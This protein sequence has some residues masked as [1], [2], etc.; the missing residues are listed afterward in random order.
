MAIDIASGI[1]HLERKEASIPGRIALIWDRC[2]STARGAAESV[3]PLGRGWTNRYAATL[4]RFEKGFRIVTPTGAVELLPDPD[5]AVES[6]GVVRHFGAFLEV[7]KLDGRYVV[8]SWNVDSGRIW[9]YC[10]LAG[11]LGVP[12]RLA[13][14][15][16][17]SGRALELD[18]DATS[19]LRR[20]RQVAEGRELLLHYGR[21]NLI[22]SV[23]LSASGESNVIA[24]YEYDAQGRLS[25]AYDAAGFGDHFEYDEK[26][27]VSRE[28][29]KDGGVFHYRYD[30]RGRCVLR[31]GLG[32]YDQKRLRFL[33]AT[34]TIEV[35]N[36]RGA[37]SRY[38]T[39]PTGQILNEWS[40][41]GAHHGRSFDA[42]GRLV[43]TVDSTGAMTRYGYDAD[44]NRSLVIDALGHRTRYRYNQ[45]HQPTL[46]VDAL[47]QEWQREYD[48]RNRLIRT[49][50]PLG[51]SWQF[52]Y[53]EADNL[54]EIVNPAGA[55]RL[56]SFSDGVLRAYKDWNGGV[57]GFAFDPFGRVTE[58]RDPLERSTR[59][60]YDRLGRPIQI[61]RPDQS[62]VLATY[63]PGGNLASYVDPN[64]HTRR[65]KHGPCGR[66]LEAHDPMGRITRYEWGTE[67][68]WLQAIVNPK[69]ERYEFFRDEAGHVV[70][71]KAFDG[72]ERT[73]KYNGEDRPVGMTTAN[74]ETIE[75]LRDACQRVT[76]QLLPDGERV[77]FEF[78]PL[79]RL[80]KAVN[81]DS[82]LV[83]ERDAAGR[84]TR[85]IQG[86][87]WVSTRY[88]LAGE[89]IE[90]SSSLGQRTVFEQDA[91][92]GL[93]QMST[94]NGFIRFEY[95]PCGREVSRLL[96]GG[97]RLDQTHD[98][99]GRLSSQR[100]TD[101]GGQRAAA[102]AE[103]IRRVYQHDAAGQIIGVDDAY[104]GRA[105]LAYD[106]AEGLIECIAPAV[107]S[108]TFGYDDTGNI[109]HTR[110]T[111]ALARDESW[112]IGVGDR[113]QQ[114]GS[115]EHRYDPEGRLVET[116]DRTTA[117]KPLTWRYEW[118][119]LDRLRTLRRPDGQTWRYAYDPLSRRIAKE[120]TEDGAS[121]CSIAFV[122]DRERLVHECSGGNV[123]ST[124]LYEP[125][126][127]SPIATI[128]GGK[129]YCIVN[130]A[131]GTPRELLDENGRVALRLQRTAWG[132]QLSP[133]PG[134][135]AQVR[136][137]IA[138]QGQWRDDESGLHYNKFRYY[139]PATGRFISQDPIRLI[140]GINL[141][142]YCRNPIN[143]IDPLGLS[144]QSDSAKRGRD[145]A[146]ADLLAAG[147][148]IK[149]EEVTMEV[150]GSRIRADFV[151]EDPA[152]NL[153][154]IEVK[155]GTGRLTEN[156]TNA[157]VFDMS[158]P[159]NASPHPGG[160]I[161]T[162]G[163]TTATFTTST[164]NV[165]KTTGAG[166]PPK[167]SS[168]TA[169][170]TVLHY[171]E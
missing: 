50:D 61:V 111:G 27:R 6:G 130:D 59:I 129:T 91:V 114:Q 21:S 43:S 165:N 66:L 54:T 44:G 168:G 62:Q 15:E 151:T 118:D 125:G 29:A 32:H 48:Q 119:V 7:F 64:G 74:G 81:S 145:A 143:W 79:G 57:H 167:G 120:C 72:G 26:H 42:F 135:P 41:L 87:H 102:G 161:D 154:V 110:R 98:A 144:C 158:N 109:A 141:Y 142:A 9:R 69:G 97:N 96:P 85:E 3:L 5:A 65:W 147:H 150:N 171:D 56:Q 14:L 136:C 28:V 12:Q 17:P 157:G 156:Q 86:E 112:T 152:G 73:F 2:Y 78:D 45:H 128:Q 137:P 155:N 113:L 162:S 107:A 89:P 164:G 19:T 20:V 77:L 160:T 122:W 76:A 47:G 83:I 88:D 104:W 31:T 170:F 22:E 139:S 51:A 149:A 132:E 90:K 138:F 25:T 11:T 16:D 126:R 52:A 123:E 84:I 68:G 36:S 10:F 93:R 37:V 24:E 1:V 163:G 58:R 39:S 18:W 30:D 99:L 70:R 53:D 159:G 67:P 92:L 40:P 55:R 131:I 13:S 124:W 148:K 105:D 127:L 153:H 95:D 116:I 80:A 38:Q 106:P 49:I 140:G 60:R 103:L 133:A 101:G 166:L 94:G 121:T 35:T 146:E 108:E 75:V 100:L 46:M 4:T 115:V 34:H 63:D 71:E 8:Q 33:D 169:T 82:S 134:E 23:T 117:D